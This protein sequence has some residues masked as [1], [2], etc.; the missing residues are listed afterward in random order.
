MRRAKGSAV[1]DAAA[2]ETEAVS[3]AT[4]STTDAG[5]MLIGFPKGV[6]S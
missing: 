2:T 1:T 5:L 6:C 3:T 4:T